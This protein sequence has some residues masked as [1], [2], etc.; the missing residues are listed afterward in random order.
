MRKL[1]LTWRFFF[2]FVALDECNAPAGNEV[3]LKICLQEQSKVTF[4]FLRSVDPESDIFPLR[5]HI[6]IRPH[7]QYVDDC[8]GCLVTC[9]SIRLLNGF[10]LVCS[11]NCK[12]SWSQPQRYIISWIYNNILFSKF[13]RNVLCHFHGE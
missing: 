2:L 6:I 10:C 5:G 4:Y 3:M 13:Y 11:H 12:S 7:L 9:E 1:F 8:N